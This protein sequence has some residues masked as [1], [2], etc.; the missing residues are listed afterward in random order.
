MG[1][2]DD[3]SRIQT[4]QLSQRILQVVRSDGMSRIQ[5]EQLTQ[6]IVSSLYWV[7]ARTGPATTNLTLE[8]S[9]CKPMPGSRYDNP[10][11][12]AFSKRQ[13]LKNLRC[14]TIRLDDSNDG[15]QALEVF[16]EWLLQ[17]LQESPRLES[18]NL[19][20]DSYFSIAAINLDHL[21][22]LELQAFRHVNVAHFAAQLPVLQT[23]CIDGFHE[24][25]DVGEIDLADCCHLRQLA[26]KYTLMRRLIRRLS[27]QL[28]S[29]L[30][31][32]YCNF[33]TIWNS[34]TKAILRSAEHIGLHCN[35]SFPP[36][37]AC[38]IFAF[39]PGMQALTMS[40]RVMRDV[41]LLARCMPVG[42]LPVGNLRVLTMHADSMRCWIPAG[43][44]NLEELV[45]IARQDLL[46]AFDD[47]EATFSTLKMF[48]AFGEPLRTH[49]YDLLVRTLPSLMRRGLCM[50]A[51]EAVLG[52]KAYSSRSKCLYLKPLKAEQLSIGALH[53]RAS[54]LARQCRCG[55]C[56]PCLRA[57]GY[58][59]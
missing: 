58:I 4:D 48:Y 17:E 55:A 46:V 31:F 44:P 14:L 49:E 38:G 22:H 51:E 56:F 59:E 33:A 16:S 11:I 10:L 40:G 19:C 41:F 39:L 53:K 18:L 6:K 26:L 30:D 57:A 15:G 50:E 21:K 12:K 29:Y 9:T 1:R 2:P 7:A 24:H 42:G 35:D 25:T 45:I 36:Q 13:P 52:S 54:Q 5:K 28:S 23:L 8:I 37:N 27:C 34:N 20:Q 43:F 32:S 47:Q 3:M